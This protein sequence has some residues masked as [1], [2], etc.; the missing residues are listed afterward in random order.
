MGGAKMKAQGTVPPDFA[1]FIT[2]LPG[3]EHRVGQGIDSKIGTIQKR[4]GILIHY[5]IGE[6]AGVY[7]D[8]AP[9][10]NWTTGELWRKKQQIASLQV[11]CVFTRSKRIVISFPEVHAN[12]YATVRDENQLADMF[13]IVFTFRPSAR[14][15]GD[16]NRNEDKPGRGRDDH[17]ASLPGTLGDKKGQPE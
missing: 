15:P 11:I 4:N 14:P 5:D 17:R 16:G 8:C 3:Y 12:F 6:L 2:L 1:G 7:T 10:C 9:L 13:L